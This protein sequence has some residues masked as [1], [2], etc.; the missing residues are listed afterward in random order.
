MSRFAWKNRGQTAQFAEKRFH[1]WPTESQNR[2][3][4]SISQGFDAPALGDTHSSLASLRPTC[5]VNLHAGFNT[6]MVENIEQDVARTLIRRWLEESNTSRAELARRSRVSKSIV[7][8]F[9]AG[10]SLAPSNSTKILAALHPHFSEAEIDTCIDD[11]KLRQFTSL[12][13]HR[14]SA[15]DSLT[16]SD[17]DYY[18]KQARASRLLADAYDS[19]ATKGQGHQAKASS[20]FFR[21]EEAFGDNFAAAAPAALMGTRLLSN[22]GDLNN[23]E[24]H[25]SRI[26]AIYTRRMGHSMVARVRSL[27]GWILIDKGDYSAAIDLFRHNLDDSSMSCD[28]EMCRDAIHMLCLGHLGLGAS[29][30]G[31]AA[32]SALEVAESYG[33]RWLANLDADHAND[34]SYGFV[35]FRLGQIAAARSQRGNLLPDHVLR[36]QALFG[37]EVPRTFVSIFKADRLLE[38]GDTRAAIRLAMQSVETDSSISYALGMARGVRIQSLALLQEARGEEALAR[39]IV[40]AALDPWSRFGA[41]TI[42]QLAQDIARHLHN[43]L[44]RKSYGALLSDIWSNFV[45][46]DDVFRILRQS[47]AENAQHV[48][49]LLR[50]FPAPPPDICDH[51]AP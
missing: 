11:F 26:E 40:S 21:A 4:P 43:T 31:D 6:T 16:A 23:A 45:S 29:L 22:I 9:L 39:A 15:G 48:N 50:S 41:S 17:Y 12:A 8:R 27:R 24:Q 36:A 10:H 5:I 3:K 44:D 49:A 32:R 51:M 46:K 28:T 37:S 47:H 7:T 1:R 14:S 42:T 25:C 20:L 18:A 33:R 38:N 13:V 30:R 34:V 19:L 35:H 2:E